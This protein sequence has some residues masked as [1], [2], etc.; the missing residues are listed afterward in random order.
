MTINKNDDAKPLVSIITA[1]F[2]SEKFIIDTFRSI[3]AQTYENWEWIITDD[4]S[5][6]RTMEILHELQKS[7]PRIKIYK[8]KE[9]YGAA[10]SRNNSLK[11]RKGDY[12]AFIDS[13]DIWYPDKLKRQLDFMGEDIDFSFT[14]FEMVDEAGLPY[15]RIIDH[16]PLTPLSY[17]DMLKKNATLGCSTVI[18]RASAFNEIKMPLIRTG[19]DY[20]TWLSLLKTNKKAYLFPEVLTKY[21]IVKGSISRNKIKKALRQWEIYRRVEGINIITS[22]YYFIHYAFKATFR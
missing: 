20:A 16:K 15:N 4:C 18:L 11:Y 9:N 3:Q 7:E 10:V 22:S 19:Q 13:D 17:K 2:N 8:N 1:T 21:R 5:T 6:D 14:S 12:I